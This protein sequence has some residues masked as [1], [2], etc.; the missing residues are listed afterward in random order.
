M[1]GSRLNVEE[2]ERIDM[3]LREDCSCAE[4]GVELGRDRST[5]SREVKAGGG[6]EAYTSGH[7]HRAA[8]TRAKRPK[9]PILAANATLAGL[10]AA[11]LGMR[12]GPAAIAAWLASP[13]S[14]TTDTVTAETIY[15]AVWAN[16]TRGLPAGIWKLLPSR[17]RTRL[18]RGARKARSGRPGP[19]GPF[20][21]VAARP[22]AA[23][24]RVEPGH[25]EGDLII[26]GR[27]KSALAV[28][29]ERASRK[30]L[31]V[32]L[33]TGY[34]AGQVLDAVHARLLG[35]P[36]IHR[37]TLTWD[38][39]REMTEWPE[40]ERRLGLDTYFCE[41]HSP[42][43]KGTVENTNRILRRYLPSGVDLAQVT[44][45]RLREIEET[46]NTMPRRIHHWAT[47]HEVFSRHLVAT[48]A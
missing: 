13:A 17:Q 22:A 40:L 1:A 8:T 7:A 33:H 3:R 35:L 11:R 28:L 4:I 48:A 25:W 16:G 5:I 30:T 32:G 18:T 26:G 20:K 34:R 15:Q 12:W 27:N 38:Q 43:Q 39:G 45:A 14:P 24:A 46:I 37:L 29:V 6:R 36:P 42:W 21:P 9:I 47:A 10:V 31:L 44:T 2:R 41:P 23:A 19:L